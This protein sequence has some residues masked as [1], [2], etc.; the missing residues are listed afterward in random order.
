M[1]L[2]NACNCACRGQD[3]NKVN[4]ARRNRPSLRIMAFTAKEKGAHSQTTRVGPEKASRLEAEPQTKLHGARANRTTGFPE[5]V[6]ADLV[7]CSP[8]T[9][10][11]FD[12]TTLED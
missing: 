2:P 6:A 10:H 8:S 12:V 7:I 5:E 11:H 1:I 4:A 3:R 9:C